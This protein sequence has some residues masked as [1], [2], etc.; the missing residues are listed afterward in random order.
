MDTGQSNTESGTKEALVERR[1][2]TARK[3]L[4][5]KAEIIPYDRA[6]LDSVTELRQRYFAHL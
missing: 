2:T 5:H 6:L 3:L 4:G 1:T